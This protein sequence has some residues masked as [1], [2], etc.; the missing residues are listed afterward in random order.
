M[1]YLK[2]PIFGAAAD[3]PCHK[4]TWNCYLIHRRAVSKCHVLK[5]YL[6]QWSTCVFEMSALW[7]SVHDSSL[8]SFILGC[9]FVVKLI[10]L[11]YHAQH[12]Q[13]ISISSTL[14]HWKIFYIK[15]VDHNGLYIVLTV[16]YEL[17]MRYESF[18]ADAH[19]NLNCLDNFLCRPEIPVYWNPLVISGENGFILRFHFPY[20]VSCI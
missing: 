7:L 4:P 12:N 10:T 19:W 13:S 14:T 5:Q 18:Q 11:Q 2:P 15:V 20:S 8:Y 9:R 3:F 17:C 16:Q 6:L 1:N